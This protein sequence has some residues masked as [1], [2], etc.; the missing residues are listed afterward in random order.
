MKDW[1]YNEYK[2]VGINFENED[3][4]RI[5][6]EKF[7]KQR[8]VKQELQFIKDVLG[9]SKEHKILEIGTGTGE[10]AIGLSK[11]CKKVIAADV[12]K[13][14]LSYAEKKINALSIKNIELLHGGFL[15]ESYLPESF[16]SVISSLTLHHLPDFWKLVAL[17]NVYKILKPGGIF[18]LTDCILSFDMNSYDENISLFLNTVRQS[19]GEKIAEEI[20]I[21]IRDEYPTYDWVIKNMLIKAGF[22][23]LKDLKHTELI[24]TV[25]CEK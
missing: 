8:N 7:K 25:I 9:I 3:E 10:F 18:L 13:T 12:S 20:T 2:Q 11:F 16:D 1:H 15:Y 17:K 4:V 22:N 21:N 24:S 23:I 5:Y 14:M 6:D 19:A